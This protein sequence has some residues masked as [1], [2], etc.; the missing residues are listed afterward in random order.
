MALALSSG[1]SDY[2]VR[3]E[4]VWYMAFEKLPYMVI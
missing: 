1:T 4:G 3:A 2:S